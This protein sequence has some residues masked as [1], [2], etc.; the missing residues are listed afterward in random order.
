[1]VA[2]ANIF[3]RASPLKVDNLFRRMQLVSAGLYSWVTA[4]TMR[5]RRSASSG[6]C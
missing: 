2:V 4:A 6:C 5:R 3:R 1:M